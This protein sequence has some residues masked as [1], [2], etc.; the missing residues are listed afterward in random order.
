M[1][2]RRFLGHSVAA[3]LTAPMPMPVIGEGQVRLPPTRRSEPIRRAVVENAPSRSMKLFLCGDMMTG[4]GIDQILLHPSEPHLYEPYVRSASQYVALAEAKTGPLE[5]P[6]GFGYVWGDALAILER[7]R[8]DARIINL[9]TAVTT[10]EDAWPAKGIHYRMHPANVPCLVAAQIDCC[11]LANNHV[12]D[13]GYHGLSETLTTLRSAGI[14]TA[15]AGINAAAA[16]APAIIDARDGLRVLVFA[17]GTA[18][19]GFPREWAATDARAGVNFLDELSER[20]VEAVAQVQGTKRTGDVAVAAI[21]WGANWGY[22]VPRMQREFAHRLIDR[23]NIDV[24]QGHSSHHPKG[25]EVY[26]DHLIL[27]GCGDFLNDYEGIGGHESFRADLA[28]AYFASLDSGTGRLTRLALAPMQIRRLR[29]NHASAADARW[30]EQTLTRQ[31]KR[32]G[33]RVALDSN[34]LVLQWNGH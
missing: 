29:V 30:L 18:S 20:A 21:H 1:N 4:R 2:R 5:R 28:V 13:W 23:A 27:Y 3:L 15:G 10:S 8:P 25:I 32:F 24:V 11:T 19:A 33:T 14:R 7:E 31:G 9:E 22:E 6:V 16:V 17:F 26:R 34:M 12:L